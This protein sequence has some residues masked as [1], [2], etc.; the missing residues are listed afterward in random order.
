MYATVHNAAADG[1]KNAS[2]A[3]GTSGPIQKPDSISKIGNTVEQIRGAFQ[4]SQ[5]AF[6]F[7]YRVYVRA[8]GIRQLV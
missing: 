8:L 6:L 3:S 7:S 2:D 1:T 4:T 5:H